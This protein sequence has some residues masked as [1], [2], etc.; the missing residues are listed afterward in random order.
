MLLGLV[1]LTTLISLP[2]LVCGQQC[3]ANPLCECSAQDGTDIMCL[4]LDR[5]LT[6]FQSSNV[7]YRR[8]HISS[9]QRFSIAK[10]AFKG[11]RVSNLI[12]GPTRMSTLGCTDFAGLASEL[13]TLEFKNNMELTAIPSCVLSPLVKLRKVTFFQNGI[14]TLQRDDFASLSQLKSLHLSWNNIST[15][16]SGSFA[17]LVNLQTLNLNGNALKQ[18]DGSLFSDLRNLQKLYLQDNN[19]DSLP[20]ELF[21]MTT[22]LKFLYLRNNRIASFPNRLLSKLVTLSGLYASGNRLAD[23]PVDF[24]YSTRALRILDLN[25]NHLGMVNPDAFRGLQNLEYL[26]LNNN[27]K[28][29]DIA[30]NNIEALLIDVFKYWPRIKTIHSSNNSITTLRAG[31]FKNLRTLTRLNLE[32]NKLTEIPRNAFAN[33]PR[34][35]YVYLQHNMIRRI[36]NSVILGLGP[37]LREMNLS[38]NDL[39]SESITYLLQRIPVFYDLRILD[40]S[41]NALPALTPVTMTTFANLFRL[42]LKNCSLT[43]TTDFEGAVLPANIDV[44]SNSLRTFGKSERSVI[45]SGSV[46][47]VDVSENDLQEVSIVFNHGNFMTGRLDVSQNQIENVTVHASMDAVFK[48]IR[49]RRNRLKLPVMFSNETSIDLLDLSDNSLKNIAV[50]PV[51]VSNGGSLGD[52]NPCASSFVN[53]LNLSRNAIVDIFPSACLGRVKILD[54]SYNQLEIFSSLMPTSDASTFRLLHLKLMGNRL[55]MISPERLGGVME[56]DLRWNKIA[57]LN[58]ASQI[59]SRTNLQKL[60]LAGNPLNCDCEGTSLRNNSMID[61]LDDARCQFPQ[62]LKFYLVACYSLADCATNSTS[63]TEESSTTTTT[64]T[65]CKKDFGVST[66]PFS[67]ESNND[68]VELQWSVSGPGTGYIDHFRLTSKDVSG[69]MVKQ[70]LIPASDRSAVL[71]DL[72]CGHQY[73]ICLQPSLSTRTATDAVCRNVKLYE[74]LCIEQRV[75][76]PVGIENLTFRRDKETVILDWSVVGSGQVYIQYLSLEY[77]DSVRPFEVMK[78]TLQTDQRSYVLRGLQTDHSYKV[79]ITGQLNYGPSTTQVCT[80]VTAVSESSTVARDTA[81][82]VVI[83]LIVIIVVVIVLVWKRKQLRLCFQRRQNSTNINGDEIHERVDNSGTRESH[84]Q[85]MSNTGYMNNAYDGDSFN[86]DLN[87]DFQKSDLQHDSDPSQV[88]LENVNGSR[89]RSGRLDEDLDS[90][91]V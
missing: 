24:F 39:S 52:W 72:L 25:S 73:S 22:N 30:G 32:N 12:I 8:L 76:K 14:S 44:S 29:S 41:H 83:V 86:P 7:L 60:Y 77:M 85:P 20:E 49:L 48:L 70:R 82:A 63:G 37:Q 35:K 34:V 71:F 54:L 13:N 64:P 84:Y 66:L 45:L 75:S 11:V 46:V 43:E 18:L 4:N 55:T 21:Q 67:L 3:P 33:S 51:K 58:K 57:S 78:I 28:V 68:S 38:R 90:S 9:A 27:V 5:N 80:T 91:K 65:H 87:D 62:E 40:L 42:S 88:R 89:P 36:D 19:I 61:R 81:I 10:D 23:I 59:L 2:S 74:T 47:N 69:G 17:G 16:E 6:T 53:S 31:A 26:S 56:L 15:V 50:F 79:C 1:I